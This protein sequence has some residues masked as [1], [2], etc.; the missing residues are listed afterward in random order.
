MILLQLFAVCDALKWSTTGDP[1]NKLERKRAK[2]SRNTKKFS[3][4]TSRKGNSQCSLREENNQCCKGIGLGCFGC[5]PVLLELGIPCENQKSAS[6]FFG[7]GLSSEEQRDCFCDDL[8]AQFG[9]CCD[10]HRNVC[11]HLY[12]NMKGKPIFNR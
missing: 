8:C 1:F 9:D 11:S 7:D 6:R 10:D 2:L 5:N 4:N 3:D 12:L